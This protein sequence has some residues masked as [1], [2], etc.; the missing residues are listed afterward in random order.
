MWAVRTALDWA[1]TC[2]ASEYY[3]I[4]WIF[5]TSI[6]C[7][8][9]CDSV[10]MCS[11]DW[12]KKLSLLVFFCF[13]FR[14]RRHV[15]LQSAHWTRR[16]R[17]LQYYGCV[18]LRFENEYPCLVLSTSARISH[19]ASNNIFIGLCTVIQATTVEYSRFCHSAYFMC[20]FFFCALALA[21]SVVCCMYIHIDKNV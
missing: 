9:V 15:S 21:S 7:A 16:F 20:V 14:R 18:N 10:T 2:S 6:L 13:C 5:H 8:F 17:L 1:K 11:M 3:Q 19:V 4:R 12:A